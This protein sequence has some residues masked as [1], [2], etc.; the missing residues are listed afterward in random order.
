MVIPVL[1]TFRHMQPSH[2]I[3]D[4]I[5][6]LAAKLDRFHPRIT[7]CRVAVEAARHRHM[8][9]SVFHVRVDVTVPGSELV[10]VSDTS[11]P[12]P[13]QDVY[14]ALSDAFH[15]MRRQLEDHASRV[16]GDVKDHAGR[17]PG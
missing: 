10:A 9:S 16:R 13:H 4:A 5:R 14:L 8:K 12:S 2:A 1:I 7:S 15:E 3:E 11:A 6:E 17:R